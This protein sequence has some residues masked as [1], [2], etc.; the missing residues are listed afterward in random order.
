MQWAAHLDIPYGGQSLGTYTNL[1][2]ETLLRRRCRKNLTQA[3]KRFILQHQGEICA[4]CPDE[5]KDSLEFDHIVPL[6]KGG[7]DDLENLQCLCAACHKTKTAAEG[8]SLGHVRSRFNRELF[9]QY[10]LSPVP[11]CMNCKDPGHAEFPPLG[12]KQV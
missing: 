3:D 5:L 2:F 8:A 4:L 11:P 6:S 12:P 10:V 7:R 1:V 9:D